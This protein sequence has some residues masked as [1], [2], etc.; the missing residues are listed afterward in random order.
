MSDFDLRDKSGATVC[1]PGY[2]FG[3]SKKAL[4]G[5]ID[6]RLSGNGGVSAEMRPGDSI[7]IETETGKKISVNY[8]GF[9]DQ[10]NDIFGF[11]VN[12]G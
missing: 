2:T 12:C 10:D 1:Q 7:S 9:T 6:G 11:D 4:T 5:V 3:M 8:R